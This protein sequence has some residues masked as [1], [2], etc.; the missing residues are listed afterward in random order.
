[1]IAEL[2]GTRMLA[3]VY[4]GSLYV[5]GAILGVSLAAL[6]G[7]YFLGGLLSH[8]PRRQQ[9][10]YWALGL[11]GLWIAAMPE[12][13][14]L[15]MFIFD[16]LGAVP[17]V[18]LLSLILLAVPLLLLG[19][20]SPLIIGLFSHRAFHAGS[21]AG[22]VYAVST[23]GGIL[24]TFLCGFLFIPQYGLTATAQVTGLVLMLLPLLLLLA[25][26][27]PAV[28]ALLVAV[29][30]LMSPDEPPHRNGP[31]P[32]TVLYQSEGLL[33]QLLVVDVAFTGPG[34]AQRT[35]RI[36]FLNRIAQTWINLDTGQPIWGYHHYLTTLGSLL[37]AGSRALL[38]GMGGGVLAR[39]L[40]DLGFQVDAVELDERVAEI[41]TRHF[42]LQLNGRL[43]VDDG[44]HYLR[45]ARER[46]DLIV[47][48]VFH[49]E[50]PPPH[51]LT[52][53]AFQEVRRLLNEDGLLLINFNGF[54]RG[55][56][57][58]ASRSLYQTL[59]AAG[60]HVRILPT[61]GTEA[62]RNN[63]FVASFRPLDFS[64]PRMPL[65]REGQIIDLRREFLDPDT[66]EPAAEIL[67][68]DRPVLDKLNLPAAAAWRQ[69][70]TKNYTK[71]FAEMDIP[72]FR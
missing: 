38:L 25:R 68:D 35:D 16:R 71:R 18:L 32:V 51:L 1:M 48:D 22:T 28:L 70:Y 5:W 47:I 31:A 41:A 37:P 13:A 61:R 36:L 39:Q 66:L 29:L 12:L 4:G 14:R 8:R 9:L 56:A 55:Q 58:Y 17:A 46:Y 21:T 62:T 40:Q 63:I 3:P 67:V 24:A 42:G 49:A 54:I 52:L 15:F 59:K 27:Q 60:F 7:G 64:A 10:L 2:V 30:L 34:G 44:R 11:A 23:A 57:G 69:A 45:I 65:E 6:T 20:A 50:L 33:G 19:A 26:A 72:L 43:V 53:E